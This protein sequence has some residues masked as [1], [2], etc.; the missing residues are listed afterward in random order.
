MTPIIEA[1]AI[2]PTVREFLTGL[3]IS[4]KPAIVEV[5]GRRVYIM[6]RPAGDGAIADE[7]WSV[8][9]NHRRFEL[10][11]KEVDG[12]I[13]I[14]EAV[15][16]EELNIAMDRWV[17]HVAPLPMD[18]VRK[19]HDTLVAEQLAT[20]SFIHPEGADVRSRY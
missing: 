15:E 4:T 18:D 7:P 6:V 20:N 10:V 11:N 5:R 14:E 8:E 13:N 2:N 16:L 17:Q 1:N 19:L 12:T 3:A 9:K